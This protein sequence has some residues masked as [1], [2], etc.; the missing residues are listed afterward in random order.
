VDLRILGTLEAYDDE[1]RVIE[2]GGR[3]QRV[4]LAM[5][6]VHRNEVVSVDRLVDAVWGE[7]APRG[8]QKNVQIHVSRLRKAFESASQRDGSVS[9]KP[10]VLTRANGYVLEVAPGELDVDRFLALLEEGRR[11][12]AADEFEQADQTLGDALVLYRGEPLADFAYDE[13]AQSE[14]GRLEELRLG[15][16][17]DRIDAQLALGRERDLIPELQALVAEHPL[18]ERLRG[19]LMLALYRSGRK[20]ESLRVFEDSR[21]ALAEELGLEPGESLQRLQQ[22]VLT[23]DA[24]L[25][26]PARAPV[27]RGGRAAKVPARMFAERRR[28]LLALGS[29]LL[30]GA[31]LAVAAFEI[32]RDRA[33]AGLAPVRPNTLAAIDPET[34]RVVAEIPVGARPASVIAAHGS[35]W[36]ANLD[37]DT[38]S[39]VDPNEGRVLRTISTG[40]APT[41]LASGRGAV[42]TVAGE[43]GVVL[44][45][46]PTFND[47][48]DRIGTV[49]VGTVLGG[50]PA[51]G[52]IAA[53]ADAVWAVSGGFFSTPRLFRIDLATKQVEAAVPTGNGPT[54]LAPGFGDLWMTDSFENTVSR[55]DRT[56]ALIATIPVGFGANAV[57]VGEGAVWVVNSLDDTIVRIDPERN[58][59]RTTIAVG[60]YPTSVAVGAGAVWVANRN[61]GTVSRI[62]PTTNAVV[63]TIEV[64]NRPAGLVVAAGSVWVTNQTSAATPA[65]GAVTLGGIARLTAAE[66][67][68]E[69]D[70]A[71]YPDRQISYAT[72]AKLLNYPDAPAPYGTRLVPEVAASLPAV[73]AHG[74]TYTFTIRDGFAFS[75]P[76][77]ERV[78]AQTFKHSIER[79]LHPRMGVA[80]AF[81]GDIAGQAAYQAGRARHIS[82][83][84][85]DGDKL[86]VTLVAPAP[87][88][89]ARIAMPFFCAV[90]LSTPIDPKGVRSIPSAGPF[91]IA[92]HEP[93]RRIVLRSN[94]NYHGSRPQRLREIRYTI[95]SAPS[96]NV[97]DVEAGRSDYLAD[98]F[99]PEDRDLEARLA[100]RYGP[101][102]AAA[103]SGGQ[104]YFVNPWFA[105]A[106]LGLNT[107]RPLFSDIDWRKA[108]NYAIDRRA[109]ARIG[110][111]VTGPF[112]AIPTD[113]YVPPTMPGA[114]RTTLYPPGGDLR[115]A[116]RLAPDDRR[117]ALLYTCNLA[118]CR[119]QAHTIRSNLAAIGLDVQVREFPVVELFERAGTKGEPFDIITAHWG[120]DYADPSDFLNVLLGQQIHPSGNLN[121]AYYTDPDVA[122]K[123]D[124]VARLTGEARYRGYAALSVELARDAAPWVAYASGTSRDFFSSR[125]GC[126]VFHP[127]YG[128][129]LAALCTRPEGG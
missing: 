113:H 48:V 74:R 121:L 86:S 118:L 82:G 43:R 2:L 78:T 14:I 63:E 20:P 40:T 31:A 85:A 94:P 18:R 102:S 122:R 5:L 21:R 37:D 4:V 125:M 117:A 108:V 11:A 35:L 66:D 53:T 38:V 64:G 34:N 70:P 65:P 84:V 13:F 67:H 25:S 77:R 93:N 105:L 19:Q 6:L 96:T 69:T 15:A 45:I 46:D 30:L 33:A 60:R 52:A 72:C 56:G 116:R 128:I 73:S 99:I 8:A 3:Q 107:S 39:R 91:Y 103:R 81:V 59:V 22:A 120:A 127:V 62:D 54:A 104:R 58:S 119:Q 32:G 124:R 98:G 23:D 55:F 80:G 44:R 28:A 10:I 111:L 29:S 26:A 110:N 49:E 1:G 95:G 27:P 76:L 90:P 114:P 42:W 41:A 16:V 83:V 61:D 51:T 9:R 101:A 50:A 47:V 100:A 24:S 12:L 97:A 36:V 123:L 89:L 88:F 71:L 115:V 68:F 7:R 109:L 17:E 75:P 79:S 87:D 112:P 129:D 126:Q 106:F 92:E 57:A